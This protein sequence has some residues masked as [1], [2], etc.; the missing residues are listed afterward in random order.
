MSS[1]KWRIAFLHFLR[2]VLSKINYPRRRPQHL[3]VPWATQCWH[4]PRIN[5][6]SCTT[7]RKAPP[8]PISFA[9]SKLSSCPSSHA[10]THK[11]HIQ[12][13]TINNNKCRNGVNRQKK[14]PLK[15]FLF[16]SRVVIVVWPSLGSP[17]KLSTFRRAGLVSQGFVNDVWSGNNTTTRRSN[18]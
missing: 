8:G 14:N 3:T 17:W 11:K 7:C 13:R 15:H 5:Y 4:R 6:N 18:V 2:R 12:T 1:P 16:L 9:A 10:C